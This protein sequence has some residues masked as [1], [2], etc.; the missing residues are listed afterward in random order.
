MQS[1][2]IGGKAPLSYKYLAKLDG[3]D[4]PDIIYFDKTNKFFIDAVSDYIIKRYEKPL[5]MRVIKEKYPYIT[6]MQKNYLFTHTDRY[7]ADDEIGYEARKKLISES[8]KGYA[9]EGKNMLYME[10]FLNFRLRKYESLLEDMAERILDDRLMEQEYEEFISLLKY[11]IN[12]NEQRPD[13]VNVLVRADGVYELFNEDGK[14]IT[15]ESLSE[16]LPEERAGKDISF[17]DLL[18]SMLITLAPRKIIVHGGEKIENSELFETISKVFDD[19]MVYCSG[20]PLC[21]H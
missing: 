9:E 2:I 17:D 20:C 21:A 1:S 7:N 4:E 11:F 13:E 10:G 14:N 12:I 15:K 19:N 6:Q 16:F 3:K 5:L 18:I 8:L